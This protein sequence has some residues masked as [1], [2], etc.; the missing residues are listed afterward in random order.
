MAKLWRNV[1]V[2]MFLIPVGVAELAAQ[3]LVV[4][5]TAALQISDAWVRVLPPGQK[6]TAA[7]LT[8]LNNGAAAGNIIGASAD[9]VAASVEIH[10]T[11]SSDGMTR[12]VQIQALPLAAGDKLVLSPGGTHLMLLDLHHMPQPGD[13]VRL[14]L[15]LA[16]GQQSCADAPARKAAPQAGD[17][18]HK[19]H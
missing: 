7:Y 11:T 15:Q 16:S 1:L 6:S 3:E 18:V 12:M 9:D 17:H 19:H 5:D 2:A 10:T 13:V 4:G 14:C 8:V